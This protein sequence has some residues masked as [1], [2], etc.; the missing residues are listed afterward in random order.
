MF[1][2]HAIHV[3]L[4]LQPLFFGFG[5]KLNKKIGGESFEFLDESHLAKTKVLKGLFRDSNL[6]H[7]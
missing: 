7:F 4:V 5:H 6:R 2:F 3:C 1:D